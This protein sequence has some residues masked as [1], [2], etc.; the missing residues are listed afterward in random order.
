MNIQKVKIGYWFSTIVIDLM[1]LVYLSYTKLL[2]GIIPILDGDSYIPQIFT[3]LSIFLLVIINGIPRKSFLIFECLFLLVIVFWGTFTGLSNVSNDEKVIIYLRAF[4]YIYIFLAVPIAIEIKK[5]KV[6]LRNF[7]KKLVI[8]CLGSLTFRTII[9]LYF[10]LSGKVIFSNI[11]EEN[12][13]SMWLR[14]DRLR[15]NPP[16]LVLIFVPIVFYLLITTKSVRNKI[17]WVMALVL[18]IMYSAFIHQSRAMLIYQVC[19]LILMYLLQNVSN[20]KTILRWCI[21]LFA[22]VIVVNTSS[23][24]DFI[25]T[26]STNNSA[27]GNS[28]SLRLLT[29]GYVFQR[30][31]ENPFSGSGIIVDTTSV[32]G[33][34]LSDIG[35]F[36]SI[37][38]FGI[39]MIVVFVFIFS[40]T[41]YITKKLKDC[42]L[43]NESILILGMTVQVL[44]IGINIDCFYPIFSFAVPFFIG[45]SEGIY[46]KSNSYFKS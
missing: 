32:F 9:S 39:F 35:I 24:N 46:L 38:M 34:D 17:G 2:G 45:I 6:E 12:A 5:N 18:G 8:L 21:L 1:L 15:V 41:L 30:L 20:R 4:N 14:N 25:D 19:T 27:Y 42:K 16:C 33:A 44:L 26:F 23:F 3:I 43:R 7:L 29:Y 10:S 36:Y 40:R 28:T 13:V 37:S 22:I 31:L 11:A